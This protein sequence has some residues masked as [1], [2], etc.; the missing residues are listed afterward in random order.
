MSNDS[1]LRCRMLPLALVAL[2]GLS[3][4]NDCTLFSPGSWS[5]TRRGDIL[6]I[7]YGRDADFPQV[8]ALHLDSGYFRMN[9]DP[10][11]GWGTSV[12]L[13]PAF[14]SD[15]I[16]HQGAPVAAE[17][18]IDGCDL[19]ITLAGTIAGLQ[20]SGEVRLS[21]PAN[22]TLV[23]VVT[24]HVS[25][26]ATLDNRPGE[27]FKLVMLSSMHESDTV[28]DALAA[29]V[30]MQPLGLPAS[31]WIV[32]PPASGRSFGLT[33]GTSS[34]KTNAP[35]IEVTFDNPQTITG[36]VTPSA[37]PN[38]DNVGLWAAVS[39]VPASWQYTLTARAE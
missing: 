7:A 35:T 14:W 4:C 30:E 29:F 21:P 9:T 12:I 33:G 31:G 10:G 39:A 24:I 15:G 6:E 23:A 26:S 11:S 37:D 16:Y 36:W 25:G 38:D 1:T 19:R 22:N 3:A 2:L 13:L 34:W 27:A 32:Q 5:V 17:W 28:W 18:T 20:V 8:A